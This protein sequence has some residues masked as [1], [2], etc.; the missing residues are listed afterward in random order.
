MTAPPVN[1]TANEILAALSKAE[2]SRAE[3]ETEAGQATVA[4][5][6]SS[7][8]PVEAISMVSPAT[9]GTMFDDDQTSDTFGNV[10]KN[11]EPPK[12]KDATSD[13]CDQFIF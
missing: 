2:A 13:R 12:G 4:T 6:R 10:F 9:F 8:I 7:K 1:A 3:T 11:L 5:R